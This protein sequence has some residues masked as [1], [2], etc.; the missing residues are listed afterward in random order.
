MVNID[1]VTLA[2]NPA[3]LRAIARERAACLGVY[4]STIQPGRVAMGD[5]VSIEY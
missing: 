4:G 5:T 2:R 1:P 3:V